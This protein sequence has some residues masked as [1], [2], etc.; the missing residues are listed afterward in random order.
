MAYTDNTPRRRSFSRRF[1][2]SSPRLLAQSNARSVS[3]SP[4][5]SRWR[6]AMGANLKMRD[7]WEVL[8]WAGA[9]L[10]PLAGYA[11]ISSRVDFWGASDGFPKEPHFCTPGALCGGWIAH[12]FSAGRAG[13][14]TQLSWEQRLGQLALP[15][16]P[17]GVVRGPAL[18]PG[19]GG[20]QAKA[21]PLQK[22]GLVWTFSLNSSAVQHRWT[23][24]LT[25][26]AVLV[27]SRSTV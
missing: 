25:H 27:P 4:Y 2:L 21:V 12:C 19:P 26:H 14:G 15:A 18:L 5:L 16:D 3:G 11:F 9:A 24:R 17:K 8:L 23:L 7:I 20:C 6:D 1:Q 13:G 10:V 22:K